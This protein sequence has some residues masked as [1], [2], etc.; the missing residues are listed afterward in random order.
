MGLEG[1]AFP[2]PQHQLGTEEEFAAKYA[3]LQSPSDLRT[4]LDFATKVMLYQPAA[5]LPRVMPSPS[6]NAAE[7]SVYD[8]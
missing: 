1:L 7:A 3:F 2:P 5:L 6:Q 4:L 8:L